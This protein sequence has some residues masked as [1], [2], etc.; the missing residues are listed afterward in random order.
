MN[1]PNHPAAAGGN[2]TLR[3]MTR[4]E[5]DQ[6][7]DWAA[8]EGWNPGHGD[9][10]CFYAADPGGFFVALLDGRPAGSISAV[11]YG[12]D[13]GFIGLFLGPTLLA[14]GQVLIREWIDHADYD[15]SPSI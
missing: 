6:A 15:E 3:Q 11:R 5:L 10:D 12:N 14:L 7:I 1:N 9:A 8:A 2:V 13:F 4:A